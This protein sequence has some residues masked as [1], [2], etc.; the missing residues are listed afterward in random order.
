MS[1]RIRRVPDWG[2]LGPQM[3]AL[4]KEAWRV[5]V[6][7]YCTAPPGRGALVDA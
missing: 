7:H 1:K 5:F 6:Y 3:R 4:P 2:K